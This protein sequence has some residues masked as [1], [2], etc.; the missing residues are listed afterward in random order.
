[1][2]NLTI[3][4]GDDQALPGNIFWHDAYITQH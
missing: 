1:V 3:T 4:A 2:G